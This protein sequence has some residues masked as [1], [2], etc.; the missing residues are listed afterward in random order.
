NIVLAL[1]SSV[2]DIDKVENLI[3]FCPIKEEMEMLKV[4]DLRKN[5]NT[6]NN[7]AK[8]IIF[9]LI[10]MAGLSVGFKFDSL[11]KLP[12]IHARNNKMT[13]M[14]H[15]CKIDIPKSFNNILY[16]TMVLKNFID[17]EIA[18]AD[19]TNFDFMFIALIWKFDFAPFMILIIA[20]LND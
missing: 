18:G 15:L 4:N 9:F 17:I 7:A 6:I 13:L 5:L 16:Y 11:F 10:S 8:E 2:L 1:D 12:D 20:I 14:H 19:A 3:K